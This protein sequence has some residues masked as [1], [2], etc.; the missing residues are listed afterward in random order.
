MKKHQI[1]NLDQKNTVESEVKLELGMTYYVVLRWTTSFGLQY[2]SNSNG[3]KV[4]EDEETPNLKLRSI[5]DIEEQEPVKRAHVLVNQAD[6]PL[7]SNGVVFSFDITCPIDAENRCRQSQ[8]SVGDYLLEIYGPPEFQ[9][10]LRNYDQNEAFRTIPK[11]LDL[12]DDDD[13]DDIGSGGGGGGNAGF[14]YGAAIGIAIAIV[15]LCFALFCIAVLVMNIIG[16]ALGGEDGKLS[17][18]VGNRSGNINEDT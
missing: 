11:G 15:A 17:R 18:D 9:N 5:E 14:G 7:A 2:Y 13:D 10:G 6:S 12:A 8:T 3:V 4:S 1:L 16:G